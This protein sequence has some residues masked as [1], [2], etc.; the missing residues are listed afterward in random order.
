MFSEFGGKTKNPTGRRENKT[1]YTKRLWAFSFKN[2]TSLTSF[3][4]C[5]HCCSDKNILKGAATC[6]SSSFLLKAL[7]PSQET[8][9]NFRPLR[10][11]F[12]ALLHS[13]LMT[14]LGVLNMLSGGRPEDEEVGQQ[15][16]DAHET[17]RYSSCKPK[18]VPQNVANVL[19]QVEKLQLE[20]LE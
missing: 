13:R 9:T 1:Y 20:N 15:T 12:V 8:Q 3:K 17:R 14:T 19:K 2:K 6:C 16:Q 11:M 10:I 5:Q 4:L 18:Q 7:N